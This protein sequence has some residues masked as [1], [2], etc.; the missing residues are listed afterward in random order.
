M[1]RKWT[2]LI[3]LLLVGLI[4]AQSRYSREFRKTYTAPEEI[5]S[6]AGSMTFDQAM[7]IFNDLSKKFK[8]KVIV[9]PERRNFPIGLEI[10]HQHW[11]DALEQILKHHGL[12]YEEYADYIRIIST[13]AEVEKQQGDSKALR[14]FY[15]REVVFSAIFFETNHARLREAGM[16]WDFFRGKDVNLNSKMSA[17]DNRTGLFEVQ[18]EPDLDFGSLLAMFKALESDQIGEVIA[19]PQITVKSG[20]EGR[21]QVGSDVAVTIRD[22]A[23]NSVTQFFSTGSII[24]VKPLVI[25]KDSIDFINVDLEVERSKST[26]GNTGLEIKKSA[27]KTS[28]LMLDGEET[29]IGGL[30]VTEETKTRD[31]I[32][33]LKNLPWWVFGLRY[34]FGYES[35]QVTKNELLILLKADLLPTLQ[36]RFEDK[37]KRTRQKQIL[38]LERRK[39]NLRMKELKEL[40]KTG[41]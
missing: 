13:A 30:Y 41:R 1:M 37:L 5:V 14:E 34:I 26:G 28:V 8:N 16:S 2:L 38:Q 32:P 22:F 39:Q 27:A 7:L 19:S 21:I 29:I 24:K 40:W 18:V 36:D 10:D 35:K 3:L 17:A 31:G 20:D 9:D 33:F 25:R 12:W 4:F 23:G 6:L 15:T 11:L